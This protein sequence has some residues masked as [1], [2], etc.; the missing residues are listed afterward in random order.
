MNVRFGRR[1][2]LPTHLGHPVVNN[3]YLTVSYVP[4][5]LPHTHTLFTLLTLVFHLYNPILLLPLQSRHNKQTDH[6]VAFSP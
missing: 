2:W 1:E 6:S 4:P 5:P 3:P